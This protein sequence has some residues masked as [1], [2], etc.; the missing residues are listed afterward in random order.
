MIVNDVEIGNIRLDEEIRGLANY[1]DQSYAGINQHVAQH[2]HQ[3]VTGQSEGRGA[4]DDVAGRE[5]RYQIAQTPGYADQGIK[6][7]RFV[8]DRNV[9]GAVEQ[10]RHLGDLQQDRLLVWSKL[11]PGG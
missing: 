9:E 10:L 7:D 2:P 1:W 8:D 5:E 11:S 6:S 3:F 4:D